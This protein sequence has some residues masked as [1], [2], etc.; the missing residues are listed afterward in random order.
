MN[1]EEFIENNKL[2][3][4]D[5]WFLPSKI[6]TH[7]VKYLGW[8]IKEGT[9]LESF[10]KEFNGIDIICTNPN[11]YEDGWVI[12]E[13]RS[14]FIQSS[15]WM[16]FICEDKEYVS[17]YAWL[18]DFSIKDLGKIEWEIQKDWIIVRK[19]NNELLAQFDDWEECPKRKEVEKNVKQ[20]K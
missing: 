2:E 11:F 7:D 19:R 5:E 8:K 9:A 14:S 20:V 4:F 10:S 6:F 18:K 17:F 1:Y 16:K 15:G 3:D 12:A 13:S